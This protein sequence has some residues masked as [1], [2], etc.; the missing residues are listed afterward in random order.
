MI[1]TLS[2]IGGISAYDIPSQQGMISPFRSV[3]WSD[4]EKKLTGPSPAEERF[5]QFSANHPRAQT[6]RA[7][8]DIT[9]WI[10]NLAY[11]P[12]VPLGNLNVGLIAR[13]FSYV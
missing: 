12:E 7:L 9:M 13:T 5:W 2:L 3:S 10:V 4:N 1:K 6:A 8:K 11:R